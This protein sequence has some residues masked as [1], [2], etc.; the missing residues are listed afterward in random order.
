MGRTRSSC[1]PLR[2]A[3]S[4]WRSVSTPDILVWKGKYYLYYQAY[5]Q[6]P[7]GPGT[8]ETIV[9]WLVRLPILLTAHGHLLIKR[10]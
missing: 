4:R 8:K 10:S 1:T 6:M 5:T 7:G 3:L 9:L 2:E